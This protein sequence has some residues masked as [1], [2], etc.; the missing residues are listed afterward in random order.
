ME[1]GL[2]GHPTPGLFTKPNFCIVG[3]GSS[4]SPF[5]NM[6]MAK[7]NLAYRNVQSI[8]D[9]KLS[10]A[11]KSKAQMYRT[12]IQLGSY[13]RQQFYEEPNRTHWLY[14]ISIWS[15][16]SFTERDLHSLAM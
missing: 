10:S 2:H 14:Q 3:T 16:F 1:I 7:S 6:E 4:L 13:A 8:V 9:L 11:I 12:G 5:Q 15:S